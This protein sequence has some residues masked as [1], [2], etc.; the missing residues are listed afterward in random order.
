MS[1]A[2]IILSFDRQRLKRFLGRGLFGVFLT[3]ARTRAKQFLFVVNA[4]LENLF[5]VRPGFVYN[6]IVRK[7]LVF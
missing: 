7:S 6:L 4:Y 1:S 5:V 2:V 3:T